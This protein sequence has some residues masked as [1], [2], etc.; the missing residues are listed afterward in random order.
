MGDRGGTLMELSTRPMVL[1]YL[2]SSLLSDGSFNMFRSL[3]AVLIAAVV[4]VGVPVAA[5]IATA[6][7][8][9]QASSSETI[10]SMGTAL[11]TPAI[12][13]WG[14]TGLLGVGAMVGFGATVAR[15]GPRRLGTVAVAPLEAAPEV[16]RSFA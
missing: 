15:R 12:L 8:V 4:L 6:T 13:V 3:L 9:V 2:A 1:E 14:A 16:A 5:T 11:H 10:G 7:V